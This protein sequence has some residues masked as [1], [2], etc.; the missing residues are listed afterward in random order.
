MLTA[1]KWQDWLHPRGKDG[2]FIE[3]QSF[4]NV[5]ASEN[6]LLSDRTAVRRRAKISDLRPEGAYVAYQ[7]VEGN[8]IPS[9]D[10]AGFPALIPV[11]QLSTK[12][13]TAPKALAHLQPGESARKEVQDALV[14]AMSQDDYDVKIAE[15]NAQIHEKHP[16]QA[17]IVSTGQGAITDAEM[18]SHLGFIA[19]VHSQYLE[20]EGLGYDSAF[21]DSFGLWSEEWQQIFDAVVDEVYDEVTVNQSKPKNRRAIMLGGLPGAGKSSTLDAMAQ[22]GSFRKDEWITINPDL[23]KDKM[24]ERGLH[25]DIEGLAPAETASFVHAASSEM[26]YM[27]E[28]L[29]SVE[30]YNLI[31]D[32]TMGGTARAGQKPNYEQVTDHLGNWDYVVDGVF[33][34]VDP[35]TSRERVALRH[36]QGLD[37]L[38]TGRSRRPDDPE[39]VN[40]GRVV[41]DSV[42]ADNILD[43]NDPDAQRYNSANARN[44][45]QMKATFVRWAEWD[46]TGKKPVFIG[47]SG[48]GPDDTEGTPGFY[49]EEQ[50]A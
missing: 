24:F 16:E 3:K 17:A 22:S 15:I 18:E 30:G 7:D 5:F 46:N 20:G 8:P 43:E 10:A 28:Q 31:F 13:S 50:A 19:E 34:D 41:P 23:F 27:L 25:P 42:I 44:F 40:G 29:L 38:R 37:A 33:V 2:R 32:I 12:V 11:E 39:I 4:V 9:D 6:A 45:D 48:T 47:G 35:G 1:A 26:S 14:P 21:K 36:Q 49:P